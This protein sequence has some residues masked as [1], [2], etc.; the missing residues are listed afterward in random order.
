[1]LQQI[2]IQMQASLLLSSFFIIK[3]IFIKELYTL[4]SH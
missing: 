1:M 3:H 2:K 4:R